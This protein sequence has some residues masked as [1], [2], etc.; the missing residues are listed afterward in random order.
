MLNLNDAQTRSALALEM[1]S[2]DSLALQCAFARIER[3]RSIN[4]TWICVS[5]GK[6]RGF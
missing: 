3:A 6:R 1:Q 5:T 2:S 4:L